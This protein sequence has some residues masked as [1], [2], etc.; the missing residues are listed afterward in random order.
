M[1][2]LTWPNVRS[3]HEV[4][5][6][7]DEMFLWSFPN[8]SSIPIPAVSQWTPVQW[9]SPRQTATQALQTFG[10]PAQHSCISMAT[11]Q[12][13]KPR[14]QPCATPTLIVLYCYCQIKYSSASVYLN[15]SSLLATVLPVSYCKK[16]KKTLGCEPRAMPS[17]TV[18]SVLAHAWGSLQLGLWTKWYAWRRKSPSITRSQRSEWFLNVKG[19]KLS[20]CWI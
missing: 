8:L 14:A 7:R 20:C 11:Q 18:G 4:I 17:A 9:V 10:R 12:P 13:A 3:F 2:I 5:E 19:S 16:K 6:S 1:H 15:Y